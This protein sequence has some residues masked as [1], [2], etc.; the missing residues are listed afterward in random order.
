MAHFTKFTEK[1]IQKLTTICK[2]SLGSEMHT[3]FVEKVALLLDKHYLK[4]EL[5]PKPKLS[6][7][8]APSQNYQP[9]FEK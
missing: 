2:W 6:M 5:H 1:N 8:C 7:F 9:C 4:G 3:Q